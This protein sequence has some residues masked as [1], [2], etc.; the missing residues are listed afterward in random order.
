MSSGATTSAGRAKKEWG[1]RWE[2]LGGYGS[3]FGGGWWG[4]GKAY[5]IIPHKR[6]QI[7]SMRKSITACMVTLFCIGC[8]SDAASAANPLTGPDCATAMRNGFKGVF[9]KDG[10]LNMSFQ[11]QD[12]T[13]GSWW[14]LG[15][16]VRARGR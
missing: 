8:I 5:T 10:S 13:D 9:N 2:G 3:G 14:T 4:R 6:P 1:E 12:Y 15:Q 7:D 11:C 16:Y